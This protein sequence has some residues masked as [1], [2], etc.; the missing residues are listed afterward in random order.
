MTLLDVRVLGPVEVHRTGRVVALAPKQRQLLALLVVGW[1]ELV[2]TER[3]V[4]DLWEGRPPATARKILQKYVFELRAA[5]GAQHIV[6]A[7]RRL[8]PL[9]HLRR[10]RGIRARDVE[11]ARPGDAAVRTAAL[12]PRSP[13]G[14]ANHSP[15]SSL[16]A[17]E[18]ERTRL[19]ELRLH[20]IDLQV[21]AELAMGHHAAMVGELEQLVAEHPFA[22]DGGRS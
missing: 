17:L 21:D 1:P 3:L 6:V 16:S 20:A 9:R 22:R 7:P 4:D 12:S 2:S 10:C 18:P 13:G 19:T 5:L 15:G 14:A 8:C 11:A